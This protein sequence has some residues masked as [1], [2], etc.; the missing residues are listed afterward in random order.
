MIHRLFL[1][2]LAGLVS[3]PCFAES[4]DLNLNDDAV[5][6]VFAKDIS[7]RKL[8]LDAGWLHHQ[9]R[10]NVVNLGLQVVD[11]ASTGANPVTAAI[12]LKLFYIDP[13]FDLDGTALGLGGSLEYTLPN[14]NRIGFEGHLYFAPDV[15]TFGD[16]TEYLEVSVRARYNILRDADLYLGLRN[17]KSEFGGGSSF[18]IDTG[19]HAGIKIR[20]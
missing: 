14:Y 9:D 12:G 2:L 1:I 3:L 17:V 6:L 16:V 7:S 8:R 10:G 20:F 18:S 11:F 19:F 13:D 4:L 5:R 15:V